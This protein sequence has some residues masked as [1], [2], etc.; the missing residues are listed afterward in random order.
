VSNSIQGPSHRRGSFFSCDC[1]PKQRE[2]IAP[3]AVLHRPGTGLSLQAELGR[4]LA[5]E[6]AAFPVAAISPV[7]PPH[8]TQPSSSC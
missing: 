7:A 2:E 4:V 6:N 8:P 1:G 3:V 5:P